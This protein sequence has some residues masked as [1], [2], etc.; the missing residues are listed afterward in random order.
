MKVAFIFST[1]IASPTNG[2]RSQAF[3][4]K[5]MLENRGHSVIMINQWEKNNWK[6]FDAICF[7]LFNPT[8][9]NFLKVIYRINKNIFIAP[10]LDPHYNIISLKLYSYLGIEKLKIAN[11][12]YALRKSTNYIKG[13]LVRSNFEAKYVNIGLGIPLNKIYKVP[14]SYGKEPNSSNYNKEYHCLH[15]SLLA[16][17]KKNVKRL[18]EAAIKFN[19]K[20]KLVGNLRSKE[21]ENLLQSWIGEHNNIEYLGRLSN[22]ELDIEYS[23]A[24][25]FALPSIFE[26]VGLVALEAA[27]RGCE[28]VITNQGG[29]KEYYENMATLVNPLDT[30][31]IGLA[32]KNILD[33][34]DNHQPQ[35]QQHIHK[36]YSEER[37]C[38][39]L[40]KA[41]S[42]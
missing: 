9:L 27:M 11:D 32:I 35:L 41:L 8:M 17:S 4:W 21:E 15:V 5:R 14:L 13:V 30:N 34:K 20:L 12:Y 40:E 22:E 31:E 18:I 19:F 42:I 1:G 3:T 16:D 29:P 7:F 26:G 25:V 2:I 24:K 23:K 37:C 39:L 36:N 28:I 10:I 6:E 38:D 33:G